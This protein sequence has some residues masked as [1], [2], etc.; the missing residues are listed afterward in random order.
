MLAKANLA[1]NGFS[2]QKCGDYS[3]AFAPIFSQSSVHLEV[4]VEL[5]NGKDLD[6]LDVKQ[7]FVQIELVEDLC[8]KMPPGCGD[9]LKRLCL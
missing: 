2:Q 9:C 5:E 7:A 1:A 3:D 6:Y 4:A 8:T